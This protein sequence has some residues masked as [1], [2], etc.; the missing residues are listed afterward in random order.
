MTVIARINVETP[1]G[2][3]IVRELEKHKKLVQIEH[4]LPLCADGL[5]RETIPSEQV[6][7]EM[8]DKL[9]ELY[10]VDMRKL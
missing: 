3:K 4:E 6:F 9:S 7:E 10:G 1:A 8:W 5:Q 2:R